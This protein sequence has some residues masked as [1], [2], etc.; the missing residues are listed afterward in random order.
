MRMYQEA[1]IDNSWAVL[2]V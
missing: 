1:N 2:V